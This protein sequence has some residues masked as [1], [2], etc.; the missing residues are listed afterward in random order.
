MTYTSPLAKIPNAHFSVPFSRLWI[1][2]KK[3]RGCENKARYIAH[4]RMGSIVRV[5]PREISIDCIEGVQTIYR[6]SFEK[7]VWYARAFRGYK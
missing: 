7:D 2:S 1:L 4:S 6:S 3:W 5:G